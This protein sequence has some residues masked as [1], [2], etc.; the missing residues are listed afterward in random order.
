M[1]LSASEDIDTAIEE[2]TVEYRE[3]DDAEYI[4]FLDALGC[5]I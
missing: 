5:P 2:I 3:E 4:L 1:S